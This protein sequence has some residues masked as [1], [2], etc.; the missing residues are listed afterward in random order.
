MDARSSC[1]NDI[2]LQ[3]LLAQELLAHTKGEVMAKPCLPV[4]GYESNEE[5]DNV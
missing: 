5:N 3:A 1:T 4:L 2:Y